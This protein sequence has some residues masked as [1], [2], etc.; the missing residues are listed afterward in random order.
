MLAQLLTFAWTAP[1]IDYHALAPEIIVAVTIV[2]LI[3]LDAFTG[4]RSRW[5]SSSVAGIGL[6]F[7]LIP[8][9]TLAYDGV[10]RVM[11]GGGFVVDNYALILQAL[12][13]VAG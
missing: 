9:A 12:F 13:L 5:A 10:N 3:L 8:I 7:A 4:E 1:S 2:V 6:L 11:F